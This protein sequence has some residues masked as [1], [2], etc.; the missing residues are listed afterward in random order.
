MMPFLD[1][2][3]ITENLVTTTK[4]SSPVHHSQL[5]TVIILIKPSVILPLWVSLR[6]K[7][8]EVEVEFV[9][10]SILL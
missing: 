10:F 9:E 7:V 5:I 8:P 2:W 4:Q 3:E 1:Y 6:G